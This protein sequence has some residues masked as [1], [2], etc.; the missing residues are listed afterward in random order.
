[1][2]T[3]MSL[4]SP[5]YRHVGILYIKSDLTFKIDPIPLQT[6][7]PFI[8]E[9]VHL[10]DTGIH[11]QDEAAVEKYLAEK[12]A[13]MIDRVAAENED[14]D[15]LP[16]VRLKVRSVCVYVCVCVCV[17]LFVCLCVCVCVGVCVC[18]CVWGGRRKELFRLNVNKKKL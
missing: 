10:R 2:S 18:V 6:V 8:I 1:M 4:P 13:D 5:T 7:R 16:L 3:S 14:N 12:V 15:K 17:C 11:P 9:G